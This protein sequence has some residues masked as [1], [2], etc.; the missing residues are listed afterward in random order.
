MYPSVTVSSSFSETYRRSGTA[1]IFCRVFERLD[2]F[3]CPVSAEGADINRTRGPYRV[4]S[5]LLPRHWTSPLEMGFLSR[6]S[7]RLATWPYPAQSARSQRVDATM[8]LSIA[9][10]P[11]AIQDFT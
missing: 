4:Q 11:K 7:G 10:S 1:R 3:E 2:L 9:A 5:R 6:R 8:L